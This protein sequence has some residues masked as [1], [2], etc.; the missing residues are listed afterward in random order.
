[1]SLKKN[2]MEPF[3]SPLVSTDPNT[4]RL[5]EFKKAFDSFIKLY[6]KIEIWAQASN[7]RLTPR[8]GGLAIRYSLMQ[9]WSF[10]EIF[11]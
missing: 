5:V 7:E 8:L 10:K 1:M 6:N 2:V 4:D 11:A 9:F 3:L